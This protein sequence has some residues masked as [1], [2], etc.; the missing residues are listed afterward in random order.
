MTGNVLRTHGGTL[1]FAVLVNNPE[2]MWEAMQAV[3]TFVGA[4]AQL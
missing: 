2:N 3:D 1:T 4:L